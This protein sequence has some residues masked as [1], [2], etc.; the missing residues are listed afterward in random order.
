M[1]WSGN[2]VWMNRMMKNDMHLLPRST[3][4]SIQNFSSMVSTRGCSWSVYICIICQ[5]C[6]ACSCKAV[7]T[8]LF[9][10]C[11]IVGQLRLFFQ[12]PPVSLLLPRSWKNSCTEL[13]PTCPY[14][15]QLARY[16]L[17]Y[18]VMNRSR[19]AG[20][21]RKNRGSRRQ[22]GYERQARLEQSGYERA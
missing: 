19:E 21:W 12:R 13:Y 8:V 11:Y 10:E 6:S 7:L 14:V 2:I 16:V 18:K 15:Y 22:E 9:S 1:N 20:L 4:A 17:R 3:A 5:W